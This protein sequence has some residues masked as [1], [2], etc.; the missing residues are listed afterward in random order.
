M[1]Y[2]NGVETKQTTQAKQTTQDTPEQDVSREDRQALADAALHGDMATL[3]AA[4][5]RVLGRMSSPRKAASS[6]ENGKKGGRPP[7][8]MSEEASK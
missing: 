8:K 4:I 3:R 2:N 5:A 1:G 7:R 6:R